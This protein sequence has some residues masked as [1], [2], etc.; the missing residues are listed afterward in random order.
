MRQRRWLELIKDYDFEVYYHPVKANVVTDALSR[1]SHCN[2]LTVKP[3]EFSLCHELEKLNIEI[4]Q[5]G[6]LTTVEP[7]IKDQI[8][9]AQKESWYSLHQGKCYIWSTDRFQY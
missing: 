8:I 4:V 9:S 1:K 2:C 6:R 7:T 3:M 5:Q